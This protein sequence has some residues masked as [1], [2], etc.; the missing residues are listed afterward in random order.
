MQDTH[1]F[2]CE[3]YSLVFTLF[4]DVHQIHNRLPIKKKFEIKQWQFVSNIWHHYRRGEEFA[5]TGG[6]FLHSRTE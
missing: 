2:K 6:K 4:K 5:G 3:Q 1:L